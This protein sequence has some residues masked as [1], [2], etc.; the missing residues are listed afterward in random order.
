MRFEVKDGY[1][2]YR[3]WYSCDEY[4]FLDVYARRPV[5]AKKLAL[6]YSVGNVSVCKVKRL[7]LEN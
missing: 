6:K 5:E 1:S 4:D 2:W 3:V 7:C